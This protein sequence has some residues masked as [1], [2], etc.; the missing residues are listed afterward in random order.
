MASLSLSAGDFKQ[1]LQYIEP[2]LVASKTAQNGRLLFSLLAMKAEVYEEAGRVKE[3]QAFRK[4]AIGWG[5]YGVYERS[6][7]DT[8]LK[9]IAGLIP[10]FPNIEG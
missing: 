2:S 6:E 5:Q 9:V 1:A 10:K 7:I 3:A 4:E 8:R